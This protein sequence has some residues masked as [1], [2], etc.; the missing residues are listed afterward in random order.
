MPP[1]IRGKVI[2]S[3]KDSSP[4]TIGYSSNE[5]CVGQ[6]KHSCFSTAAAIFYFLKLERECYEP[7][8]LDEIGCHYHK[9]PFRELTSIIPCGLQLFT[10]ST[11]YH[12]LSVLRLGDMAYLLHS[13]Q[14]GFTPPYQSPCTFQECI[15]LGA[16]CFASESELN[17]FFDDL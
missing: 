14:D 8:T 13:N 15:S 12:K 6:D 5:Y 3:L 7:L 4:N 10:F 11:P 16:H 1:R 17:T 2:Y 9:K